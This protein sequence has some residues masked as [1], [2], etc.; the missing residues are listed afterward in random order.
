MT[1]AIGQNQADW[2]CTEERCGF[3]T[4]AGRK[5]Q[6]PRP[7][8]DWDVAANELEGAPDQGRDAASG[9]LQTAARAARLRTDSDAGQGGHW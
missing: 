2:P 7:H 9:S 1:R 5:Y 6:S 8:A 4:E 3:A